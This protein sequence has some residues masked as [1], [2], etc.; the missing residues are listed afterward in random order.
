LLDAADLNKAELI[1]AHRLAWRWAFWYL[2]QPDSCPLARRE[3]HALTHDTAN[4]TWF[5]IR[6]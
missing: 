1:L 5:Q 4:L 2:D 3:E 6:E